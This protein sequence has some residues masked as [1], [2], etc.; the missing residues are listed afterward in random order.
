VRGPA[1]ALR[2]LQEVGFSTAFSQEV[3]LPCLWVAI[4]GRRRPRLPVH[5]HHDYAI[6]LTWELKDTLP[7]KGLA[8]Y[9]RV[10]RRLPT[11]I[12]LDY[13]PCFY[14]LFAPETSLGGELT[15]P[16]RRILD[17]LRTHANQSTA[18]LRLHAS[19]GERRMSKAAFEKAIAELQQRFLVVRTEARYEPT[20]TYI[21]DLFERRYP[22]AVR[23]AR[24]LSRQQALERILRQYFRVVRYASAADLR[25]LFG[26][27]P[28]EVREA[29]GRLQSA[30]I[31]GPPVRL[32]GCRGSWRVCTA[33]L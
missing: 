2:F 26:L 31:I 3:N 5:T 29:L 7:E 20:F 22:A 24:S 28:A 10:L 23:A 15:L 6:G 11:L 4:C 27:H 8:F 17:R 16:A 14:R 1:S 13:L 33:P 9:G 21:W 30:G 32:R 12:S 25:S 19:F 18:Q